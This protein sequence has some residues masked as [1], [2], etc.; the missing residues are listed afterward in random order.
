MAKNCAG[1]ASLGLLVCGNR[2]RF[3]FVLKM[4]RLGSASPKIGGFP[5]RVLIWLDQTGIFD[6]KISAHSLSLR[7]WNPIVV[8]SCAGLEY[9]DNLYLL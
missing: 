2:D 3:S 6:L 8:A 7:C 4:P 5:F 1:L 9:I